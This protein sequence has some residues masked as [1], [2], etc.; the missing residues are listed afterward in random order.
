MRVRERERERERWLTS[1]ASTGRK[2]VVVATLDMTSVTPAMMTLM[3]R[4][5]AGMGRSLSVSS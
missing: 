3:Q 1:S 5:M 2:S 4:V